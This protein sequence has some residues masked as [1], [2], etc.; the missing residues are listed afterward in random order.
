M[1][2]EGRN[3]L[4]GLFEGMFPFPAAH[5]TCTVAHTLSSWC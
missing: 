2:G 5:G 3:Q 1:S 4:M